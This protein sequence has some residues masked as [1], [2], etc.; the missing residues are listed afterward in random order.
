M[1]YDSSLK[2]NELSIHEKRSIKLQHIL[3]N[4]RSPFEKAVYRMAPTI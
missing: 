3:L 1:E 4:E 2:R